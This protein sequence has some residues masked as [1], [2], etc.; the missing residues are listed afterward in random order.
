MKKALGIFIGLALIGF[1]GWQV[2]Q[3]ASISAKGSRRQRRAIAV[4]V[5]VAP[6]QNATIRDV[7]SFT[8]S[9]FPE[10]YFLV[11][12]KIAGRLEK[13]LVDIGERVKRGHLIAVLDDDEYAQQ[14]EQHRVRTLR[15]LFSGEGPGLSRIPA[16][17]DPSCCGSL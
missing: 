1:L 17:K 15:Q 5:E 14:V 3:R 13:L 8:G 4:A 6:I 12:P 11:A 2:Y 16:W 9:L 7:G 10:S